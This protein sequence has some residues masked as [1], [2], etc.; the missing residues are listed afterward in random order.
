MPSKNSAQD[1]P[2]EKT[3]PKRTPFARMS[4]PWEIN[5]EFTPSDKPPGGKLPELSEQRKAKKEP[6]EP[7]EADGP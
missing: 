4:P 5:Y 7:T 3:R 2:E 1:G 6:T